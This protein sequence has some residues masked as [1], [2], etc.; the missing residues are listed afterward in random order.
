[1]VRLLLLFL[2]TGCAASRPTSEYALGPLPSRQKLTPRAEAVKPAPKQAKVVFLDPGHGGRDPGTQMHR[3]PNLKEKTL[4]LEIAKQVEQ[5]LMS[6][7]I[8]VAMS[9]RGDTTV[10]L[11]KRVSLASSHKAAIF[12]SIHINSCPNKRISGAELW[13]YNSQNGPRT[14][15]SQKLATCLCK[16][17]SQLLPVRPRGVKSGNLHVIRETPMPA[18]LIEAA[19]LTNAGEAR[20]L[21]LPSFKTKLAGAIASGIDDYF[22]K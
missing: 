20:L 15:S 13:F 5:Q 7:G 19:F 21:S 3:W 22:K 6:L 1:M 10:S 11:E 2:L 8:T 17:F 18:V 16:R 9:R 12:V 14:K 4:T